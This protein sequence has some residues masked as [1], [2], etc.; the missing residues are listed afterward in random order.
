MQKLSTSSCDLQF[1]GKFL[2]IGCHRVQAERK[3]NVV[4]VYDLK[5]LGDDWTTADLK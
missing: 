2:V 1:A 3:N 4:T 5:R